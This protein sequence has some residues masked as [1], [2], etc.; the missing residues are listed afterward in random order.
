MS[1][2]YCLR[3]AFINSS[4]SREAATKG[5]LDIINILKSKCPT[6]E[7]THCTHL[8]RV[9]LKNFVLFYTSADDVISVMKE[10]QNYYNLNS[11]HPFYYE[12]FE[13]IV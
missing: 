1:S 12:I 13:E 8:D 7:Y 6:I 5:F 11:R 2:A 9:V 3:V 10:V 4:T